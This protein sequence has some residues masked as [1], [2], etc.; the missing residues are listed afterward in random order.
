MSARQIQAV[1]IDFHRHTF[2][3]INQVGTRLRVIPLEA[4]EAGLVTRWL[5]LAAQRALGIQE[6]DYP[7]KKA[8]KIYQ[9]RARRFGASKAAAKVLQVRRKKP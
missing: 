9:H 8:F 6:L 1:L 5:D 2:I 4:T 3:Q 7:R